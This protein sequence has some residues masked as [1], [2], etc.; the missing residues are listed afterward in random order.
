MAK[1]DFLSGNTRSLQEISCELMATGLSQQQL[2]LLVELL[3][4]KSDEPK[5]SNVRRSKRLPSIPLPQDW[6][7]NAKHYEWAKAHGRSEQWVLDMADKMRAWAISKDERKVS[8]DQCLYTFMM[9]DTT[10]PPKTPF[11]NGYR[12]NGLIGGGYA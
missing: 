1:D 4:A 2:S 8:W 3:S 11:Q 9:R 12:P 10:E 7:P 5:R 6:A